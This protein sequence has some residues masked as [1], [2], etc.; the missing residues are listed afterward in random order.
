MGGITIGQQEPADTLMPLGA[1]GAQ[2][3]F[4]WRIAPKRPPKTT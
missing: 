4:L 2:T 1:M 3:V